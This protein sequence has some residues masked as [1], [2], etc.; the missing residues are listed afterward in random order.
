MQDRVCAHAVTAH[1]EPLHTLLERFTL[2]R[3]PHTVKTAKQMKTDK[4][5]VKASPHSVALSNSYYYETDLLQR[6]SLFRTQVSHSP[7]HASDL[8]IKTAELLQ[9][10]VFDA[11]TWCSST[12]SASCYPPVTLPGGAKRMRGGKNVNTALTPPVF[13]LCLKIQPSWLTQ[14]KKKG[15]MTG[16]SFC[17]RGRG[18]GEQKPRLFCS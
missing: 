14:P 1:C 7:A 11:S 4:A 6:L 2:W 18:H 3:K 8:W 17:S 16:A 12:A 5:R 13:T 15:K 9:S 10:S